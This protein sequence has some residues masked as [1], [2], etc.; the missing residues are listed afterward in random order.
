DIREE[1]REQKNIII[2]LNK[3]EIG[4]KIMIV[5]IDIYGNEFKE[6]FILGG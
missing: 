4:S 3:E 5:Y 1:L 2:P 6:K